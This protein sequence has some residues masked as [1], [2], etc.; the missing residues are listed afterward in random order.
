MRIAVLGSR[1]LLSNYSGI[2][3]IL[4]SYLPHLA[5]RGHIVTVYGGP[6]P[7]GAGPEAASWR[8]IRCVEVRGLEGKH[9]ETL[10]RSLLSVVQAIRER[11]DL[12]LFTHQGPGIFSPIGRLARVP[13]VVWVQGLDWRR[14]KWGRAA[15]RAIRLA[16]QVAVRSASEIIVSSRGIQHYF[17]ATYGRE[18]AYIPNGIEPQGPPGEADRLAPFGLNP[19]SYALFAARLVPEKA[20]HE[21][22]AAWNELQTDKVL[23]VAGRGRDGDPYTE[24]LQRSAKPG[25][26]VFT[27]HVSGET[28]R[29]LFAHAYLFVHPSHLEGQ[30][31]ALLEALGH[32]RAVLVSNIPENLEAI[33]PGGFTF[34]VGQVDALRDR[35]E[36]LLSS[37][38]LVEGMEADVARALGAWPDWRQVALMHEE[39]YC[40]AALRRQGSLRAA[41]EPGLQPR[42]EPGTSQ[43]E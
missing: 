9:T 16:E 26:V 5:E 27:G 3:R 17:S 19:R 14:A 2:E 13:T 4:Q 30:S 37:P 12:L 11:S 42:G 7:E 36:M 8:G 28:L 6:A 15:S 39:L 20:C 40:R 29:Q 24:A 22:I 31:L 32:C 38:A 21:L 34:P 41:A 18:T 33:E 35:L 25:R 23:V 43:A 10:S 1:H